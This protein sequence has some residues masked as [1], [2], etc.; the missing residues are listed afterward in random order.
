MG[1]ASK[2]IYNVVIKNRYQ[3]LYNINESGIKRLD[4]ISKIIT[5]LFPRSINEKDFIEGFLTGKFTPLDFIP[6]DFFAWSFNS[7][8]AVT[9]DT[10]W[11]VR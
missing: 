7:A 9:R 11:A 10:A 6:P 3:N 2:S 8:S 5:Q 1:S 4:A